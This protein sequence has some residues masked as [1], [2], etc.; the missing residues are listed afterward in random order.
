MLSPAE[1]LRREDDC[2]PLRDA[3][4][5]LLLGCPPLAVGMF[6]LGCLPLSM[7][8]MPWLGWLLVLPGIPWLDWLDELLDGMLLAVCD[9]LWLLLDELLELLDCDCDCDEELEE[10]CDCDGFAGGCCCVCWL[11]QPPATT[12]P[13]TIT[14][15]SVRHLALL[16]KSSNT[17]FRSDIL[18]LLK[19]PGRCRT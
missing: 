5:S 10:D 9:W 17:A 16:R 15:A 1:R 13:S 2:S 11:L 18:S 7:V 4:L 8:G 6:A 12:A 19:R 3:L 14:D